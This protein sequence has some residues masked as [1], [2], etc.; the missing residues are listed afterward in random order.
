MSN[1][2]I[3]T[4]SYPTGYWAEHGQEIIATANEIHD[5]AWSFRE[6]RQLLSNGL[7]TR[8][9]EATGGELRNVW[10]EGLKIWLFAL[11]LQ[12]VIAAL[13]VWFSLNPDIVAVMEVSP[14][15]PVIAAAALVGMSVSTRWPV[16]TLA[17][18]AL[19][20]PAIE[21]TQNPRSID[22]VITVFVLFAV[23][24]IARFGSGRRVVSP[25]ALAALLV[26]SLLITRVWIFGPGLLLIG[27]LL[28]GL[29]VVRLDARLVAAT[30]VM[31]AFA[32]S[33]M[34]ARLTSVDPTDTFGP[35][36]PFDL[37]IG[38]V[39]ALVTFALA[40]LANHS[41]RQSAQQL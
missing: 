25:A 13:S 21:G 15:G 30:A 39:F 5:G 33:G 26:A 24:F 16:L 2:R 29:L 11:L 18:M 41:T 27:G 28:I 14:L 9:L 23:G 20:V 36:I 37:L 22:V 7:R 6:S 3:V 12:F 1:Y 10:V 34:F 4:R 8:S 17:A 40:L 19:L 32:A 31:V 35:G 38:G